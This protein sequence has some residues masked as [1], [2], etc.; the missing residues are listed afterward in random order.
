MGEERIKTMGKLSVGVPY[1]ESDPDKREVLNK[2]LSSFTGHY[3][4]LIVLA[5]KQ[6]TL[7]RAINILLETM[8]GDFLI[9]CNDDVELT[10]GSLRDLMVPNKV[11]SPLVNG[12]KTKLFHAHLWCMPRN[13]YEA[14]GPMYEGYDGFYF[15]DSDY[16][17]KIEGAGFEIVRNENVD[18]AHREP[19][20]TLGTYAGNDERMRKNREIFISRWG[21]DNLARVL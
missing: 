21:R 15:D 10:K 17:M 5:G 19:G 14:V 2:C 12:A 16:W 18:I 3:D 7:A 11:V 8:T 4:E 1:Y 9:I 20:R 13:V 6:P